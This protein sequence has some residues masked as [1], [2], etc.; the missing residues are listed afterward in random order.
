MTVETRVESDGRRR[1]VPEGPSRIPGWDI[2]YDH[3]NS[4]DPHIVIRQGEGAATRWA[5]ACPWHRE[6]SVVPTQNAER[7]LRQRG[8]A[9]W[10]TGCA[11]GRPHG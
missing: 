7:A 6:L 2:A 3:S 5:I 8:R 10:C 4:G 11:E 9:A 1:K